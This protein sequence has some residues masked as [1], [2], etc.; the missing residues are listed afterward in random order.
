MKQRSV[1]FGSWFAFCLGS[2]FFVLIYYLPIWFQAIKGASATKS[3][4]MNLP[5]VLS[6]VIVSII[7]GVCITKVGYYTP[8]M[9]AS[10]IL[11]SIG[12]GLLSTF[13]TTTN[14]SQWIGYQVIYGLGVGF[15]MQQPLIGV[16]TVLPLHD[17]PVG[18]S[19]IMF[20]QTLGGALFISIA[21][22]I[23]SNRFLANLYAAKVPGLDP[24]II[25]HIGATSLRTTVDPS[26]L[27]QVLSAYDKA[28]TQ[29]FYVSLAVSC[30]SII[31]ALG[32]EWK[33][34]KGKKIEPGV[35]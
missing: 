29:T 23:F 14:H 31:G 4:I 16:Q 5:V 12:C 34:V 10:S 15:G 2:S 8:F 11:M 26:Y 35:V 24:K 13:E 1:A 21:Q 3:G 17:I 18:T 19:I 30:L 7:A 28:I 6:L 9:I 22:N 27:P 32:M 25:I 20:I 33:S